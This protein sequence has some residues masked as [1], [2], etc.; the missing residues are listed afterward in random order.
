MSDILDCLNNIIDSNYKTIETLKRANGIIY[1]NISKPVTYGYYTFTGYSKYQVQI[2]DSD[3]QKVKII[4][5]LN[6]SGQQLVVGDHVLVYY[7]KTITDGYIA[8]K[9]GLDKS[10]ESSKPDRTLPYGYTMTN[11]LRTV[12]KISNNVHYIR[13]NPEFVPFDEEV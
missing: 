4:S 1:R 11:D 9:L 5:L 13:F 7:W 6:K 8:I 12:E 3:S 2:V 10:L